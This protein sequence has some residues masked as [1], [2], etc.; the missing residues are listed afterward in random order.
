MHYIKEE[1]GLSLHISY[2]LISDCHIDK[3]RK[4]EREIEDKEREIE[5]NKERLKN[6]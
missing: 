3:K 5:N 4:K 6:N 1:G 2:F